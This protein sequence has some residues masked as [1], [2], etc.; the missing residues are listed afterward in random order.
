[1]VRFLFI[2]AFV[3]LNT[4]AQAQQDNKTTFSAEDL[5][6]LQTQEK[7]LDGLFGKLVKGMN[8]KQRI[9]YND[10]IIP[11]LVKA[12][13]IENSFGYR[14]DS[15]PY[16]S[17]IYAPD[18]SFRI[19]TWLLKKER[20]GT[21]K[22]YGAIQM[23]T[24]ELKL[25]PLFDKSEAIDIPETQELTNEKWFGVLYY[26]ITQ[27]T[28]ADTTYYTLFGWDGHSMKSNKKIADVLFFRAGKPIFGKPMFE[29]YKDGDNAITVKS[30]MI[31]EYKEDATIALNYNPDKDAIIYDFLT[32]E[33]D[34][35]DAKQAYGKYYAY[36]PDGTYLGSQFIDGV[37]KII[38]KMFEEALETAPIPEPVLGEGRKSKNKI[39]KEMT[40]KSK[41]KKEERR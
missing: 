40:K 31:L 17:T 4:V 38:P 21:F 28:Y 6:T 25:I 7:V 2:A 1:M 32:P 16:L 36:I 9:A 12:L 8:E 35:E 26:G 41:R 27:K 3:L 37:W 33:D 13:R 19:F 5:N 14:F 29:V 39:R 18:N 30:R 15:L 24:P 10:S 22:Y 23:N 20:E 11:A 34:G